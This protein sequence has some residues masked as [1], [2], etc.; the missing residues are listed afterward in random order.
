[1]EV[2][3]TRFGLYAHVTKTSSGLQAPKNSSQHNAERGTH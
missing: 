3:E 1:M 2:G